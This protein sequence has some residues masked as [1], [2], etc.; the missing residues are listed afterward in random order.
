MADE[1][2][3]QTRPSSTKDIVLIATTGYGQDED[4]QRAIHSGFDHHLVK[5]VDF[6][7]VE[8]L[9]ASLR[10]GPESCK[11]NILEAVTM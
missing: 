7:V 4:R 2:P 9:F 5:P 6:K 11:V 3:P 1:Y 10:S 8:E